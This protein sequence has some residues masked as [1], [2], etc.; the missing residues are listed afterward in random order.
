MI[1][2]LPSPPCQNVTVK[3]PLPHLVPLIKTQELLRCKRNSFFGE[4]DG[5]VL[6]QIL[7]DTKTNPTT[8][9]VDDDDNHHALQL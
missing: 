6:G 7:G 8:H 2:P 9:V 3:L 5:F 4:E 1:D